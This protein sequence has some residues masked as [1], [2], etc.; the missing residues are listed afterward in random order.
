MSAVVAE[1]SLEIVGSCLA[2]ADFLLGRKG[3]ASFIAANDDDGLSVF[4][5][6]RILPSFS[7]LLEDDFDFVF[8][9]AGILLD[10][11]FS[12]EVESTKTGFRLFF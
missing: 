5:A 11:L 1:V 7:G 3:W 4:I 2:S 12:G 10:D 8:F 6:L 9:G